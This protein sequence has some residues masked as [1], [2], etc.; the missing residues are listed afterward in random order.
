MYLLE[1]VCLITPQT[2][3]ESLADV[4][5]GIPWPHPDICFGSRYFSLPDIFRFP[6]FLVSRYFPPRGIFRLPVFF[7]FVF[8]S[9]LYIRVPIFVLPPDDSFSLPDMFRLLPATFFAY[10]YFCASRQCFFASGSCFF[11]LFTDG[12]F[13]LTDDLFRIPVFFAP[14]RSFSLSGHVFSPYI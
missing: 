8:C 5:S 14:R 1:M 12:Y 11:A 13:S 3:Y 9:L 4:Y 2:V 6:I 7:A 10:R